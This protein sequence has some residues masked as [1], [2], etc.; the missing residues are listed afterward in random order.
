MKLLFICN[1]GMHRSKTASELLKHGFETE[2]AGLYNNI[3]SKEQ[4]KNIYKE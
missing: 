3:V 2:S 1:Q 4:L